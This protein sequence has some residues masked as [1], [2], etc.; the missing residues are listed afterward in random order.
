LKATALVAALLDQLA[1]YP[2]PYGTSSPSHASEDHNLLQALSDPVA[3]AHS[4]ADSA[5]VELP[6]PSCSTQKPRSSFA[7]MDFKIDFG[8]TAGVQTRGKKAA[9]KAAKVAQQAKWMESD[10]EGD[11]NAAGDGGDGGSGGNGGGDNGS[12]A[13]GDGGGDNGGGD[14][15]DE[16]EWAFGGGKKNKKKTSKQKQ[17][18]EEQ[19]RKEEEE[20]ANAANTLSWADETN[21]AAVNDDWTTGFATKKDKK[22]KGKKV[23]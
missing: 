23:S 16:D 17:E 9:K 11:G 20:A 8:D 22:K 21:D 19:K 6:S 18:E 4:L 13:G 3:N 2:Q 5:S 10:N 15:G 12:G 7:D 14:G 1:T